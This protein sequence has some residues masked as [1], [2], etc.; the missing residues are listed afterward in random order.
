[1][2]KRRNLVKLKFREESHVNPAFRTFHTNVEI[3]P[4]LPAMYSGGISPSDRRSL[5]STYGIAV[6]RLIWKLT[7][8][9]RVK[10]LL[11]HPYH[12]GI[13]LE[14]DAEW[15][16]GI[17]ATV[18]Q[19]F[20]HAALEKK[21][22]QVWATSTQNPQVRDYKL[23]TR[24]SNCLLMD[25]WRPLSG[26]PRKTLDAIG[27]PGSSLI[28]KLLCI[29]GVETVYI[30]HYSITVKIAPLFEWKRVQRGVKRA[31]ES[32]LGSKVRFVI[33]F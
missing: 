20:R 6:G 9:A 30:D 32:A 29:P 16:D 33:K 3:C 19:A 21:C 28:E 10:E 18:E 17:R 8:D 7:R 27:L 4:T 23:E 26:I 12:L 1:L 13:C 31:F 2:K 15:D 22:V 25:F 11:L 24:L 14:D 5:L